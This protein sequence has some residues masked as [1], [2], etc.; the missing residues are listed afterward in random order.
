MLILRIAGQLDCAEAKL[1]GTA[2]SMTAAS[3]NAIGRGFVGMSLAPPV[4]SEHREPMRPGTRLSLV[5][6]PRPFGH[7]VIAGERLR[8]AELGRKQ[9]HHPA[10]GATAD[11]GRF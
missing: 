7:G 6:E 1:A 10:L 3:M 9:R 11:E 5:A 2:A 8:S 4:C